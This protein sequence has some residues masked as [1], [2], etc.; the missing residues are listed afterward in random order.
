MSFGLTNAPVTFNRLMTDLFRK[1]LDDFVL[2]FFDNILI[3]SQIEEDHERHLRHVLE[4]LKRAK[5]YAKR[6]KCSFFVEKVAY[7]GY[8]VSKEGLTADPTKIKAINQWL[9]PKSISKVRGLLGLI[10]RCRI[11]I[12]GYALIAGPLT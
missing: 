4:T 5:L 2:V 3:Y 11:F 9:I 6:S 7:L 8:I 12:K 10:G 1:E